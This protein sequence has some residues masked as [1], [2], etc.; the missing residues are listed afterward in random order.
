M[1]FL[2]LS[3]YPAV[4]RP[5]ARQPL[6][7]HWREEVRDDRLLAGPAGEQHLDLFQLSAHRAR[8][9]HTFA[10]LAVIDARS[11]FEAGRLRRARFRGGLL[12]RDAR[13][14]VPAGHVAEGL[15]VRRGGALLAEQI[16]GADAL[17]NVVQE[18]RGHIRAAVAKQRAAEG[19]EQIEPLFGARNADVHQAALFLHLA[20][21]FHAADV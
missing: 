16:A 21:V 10:I 6:R 12:A 2:T 19:V 3:P 5:G 15:R 11:G 13:G 8:Y 18:A 14:A 9:D 7:L 20:R 17:R 4:K 1:R